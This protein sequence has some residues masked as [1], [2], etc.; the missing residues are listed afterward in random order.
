MIQRFAQR[1]L[2]WGATSLLGGALLLAAYAVT[3]RAFPPASE[4]FRIDD[5]FLGLLVLLNAL[6]AFALMRA[7]RVVGQV[8]TRR[9]AAEREMRRRKAWLESVVENMPVAVGVIDGSS[10]QLVLSNAVY[11]AL[12]Q[13]EGADVPPS[14]I[15]RSVRLF[16]RNGEAL[17]RPDWPSSRALKFGET[18]RDVEVQMETADGQRR[19][20]AVSAGPIQDDPDGTPAAVVAFS[21]IT[22]RKLAEHEQEV[23]LRRLI[24]VQEEERLHFAR[25]LHDELG[26]EV[27]AL[28][29]G[30][31]GIGTAATDELRSE[32][33]EN[34]R[35]V[36]GRLHDQVHHLAG[37]LRPPILEDLGL[38]AAVEDLALGWG[39]K[40]G[41]EV[42]LLL[43]G[44]QEPV[45]KP[46]AV[47]IYRV[48]QELMTNMARHS[49]ARSLSVAARRSGD[50]LRIVVE[51]DGRGFDS[52]NGSS[53]PVRRNGVAGMRERLAAVGGSL[54]IESGMGTGT[55]AYV[56][57]PLSNG[58]EAHDERA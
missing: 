55:A 26:Q 28:M 53:M 22:A 21:D 19:W 30:L 9:D 36:A 45:P 3:R 25:E 46:V 39:S 5:V 23:L 49:G 37:N 2:H 17:E 27:T 20:M 11:R 51:D 33:L 14:H 44:L 1:Q 24:E 41:I 34:L 18:S 56:K 31:K 47:A 29:V 13:V 54:T 6:T 48:L 32:R 42:D 38:F 16:D 58:S 7:A 52:T 15:H 35:A 8:E 43:D 40:L 12:V 4:P 50:V 10:N 57:I